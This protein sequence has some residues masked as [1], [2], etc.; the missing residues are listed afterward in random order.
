MENDGDGVMVETSAIKPP[1]DV[2]S[3]V[4]LSIKRSKQEAQE[5]KKA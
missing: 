1:W 2:G 3:A 4:P 5:T